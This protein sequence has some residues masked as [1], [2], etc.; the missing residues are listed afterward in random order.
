RKVGSAV[1]MTDQGPS[2][3]TERDL[4]RAVA[5][6][7]D[8]ATGKVEEFMTSRAITVLPTAD[9][10][11]AA[12]WMLEGNFRHLVVVGEHGEVEGVLSMR[13]LVGALL[14]L[15][16]GSAATASADMPAAALPALP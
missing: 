12:E 3:I 4:L 8:L 10:R 11:Q 1:V 16:D 2:I 14:R 5:A 6:G 13:D 7:A 15:S 9:L